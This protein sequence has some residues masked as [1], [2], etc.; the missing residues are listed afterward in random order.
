[1]LLEAA[2]VGVPVAATA[3][4]GVP[5]VM[6]TIGGGRCVDVT[7]FG[8]FLE[9]VRGMADDPGR[10]RADR[11]LVAAHYDIN[12]VADLWEGALEEAMRRV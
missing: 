3:V 2:L 5:E 4:G 6:G 1:M 12:Y 7:D 9:G 8:A 10:Y 11:D